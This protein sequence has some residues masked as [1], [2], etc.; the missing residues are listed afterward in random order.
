M[1]FRI[2]YTFD[3]FPNS[4]S[5]RCE[6]HD[7]QQCTCTE[8]HHVDPIED[9]CVPNVCT[10]D[11]PDSVPVPNHRCV[12]HNFNQCEGCPEFQHYDKALNKCSKNICQCPYGEPTDKCSK[13]LE[14]SCK[15]NSCLNSLVYC[16][17]GK[18]T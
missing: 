9:Y 11:D 17:V 2:K 13:H 1:I 6:I 12:T 7:T 10:C 8:F 18:L 14:F 16:R 3:G 15:Q 4:V 5:N